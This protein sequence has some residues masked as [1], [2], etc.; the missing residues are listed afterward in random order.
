M[1]TVTDKVLPQTPQEEWAR[2]GMI[3]RAPLFDVQ[4]ALAKRGSLLTSR[5]TL[6]LS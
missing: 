6:F 1:V 2:Q 4:T 5:F 3:H